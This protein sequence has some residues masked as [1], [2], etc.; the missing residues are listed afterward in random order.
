MHSLI[1]G[2]PE[3]GKVH[4]KI[5]PAAPLTDFDADH[6]T[7]TQ[8][9]QQQNHYHYDHH[10]DHQQQEPYQYHHYNNYHHHHHH[11]YSMVIITIRAVSKLRIYN[12]S[13]VIITIIIKQGHIASTTAW[14]MTSSGDMAEMNL[15]IYIMD[16]ANFQD[17]L[18]EITLT[19]LTN[20]ISLECMNRLYAS[21][22]DGKPITHMETIGITN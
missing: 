21:A 7:Q 20:L 15:F 6:H 2:T 17:P 1:Q 18:W 14:S 8:P 13:Y 4:L 10:L 19:M 11:Q 5:N 9:P 12:G 3:N 16:A 22:A